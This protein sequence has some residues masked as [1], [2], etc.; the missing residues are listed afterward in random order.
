MQYLKQQEITQMKKM[1]IFQQP[2][3]YQTKLKKDTQKDNSEFADMIY[4]YLIE[5]GMDKY[6]DVDSAEFKR[7]ITRACEEVLVGVY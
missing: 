4:Y 2:W 3:I 7:I 6:Y 5:Q 1:R